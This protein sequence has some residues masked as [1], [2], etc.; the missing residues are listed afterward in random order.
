MSVVYT[1]GTFDLFHSGHIALLERCKDIAGL[2]GSVIVG[3]NSDDFIIRYKKKAPIQTLQER[4]A[5][6]QACRFVDAVITNIGDEDAKPAIMLA[7]PNYVV[8]GSDWARKDYYAQMKF[9][10]DWLDEQNIG[11][12]YLPYTKGIS[13][14]QIRNSMR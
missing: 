10:Q 6:L 14:T 13:S 8:I 9:T 5:V 12:I 3:V 2:Y 4:T 11:L 1:C 7:K